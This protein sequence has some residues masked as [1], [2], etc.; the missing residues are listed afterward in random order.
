M[1]MVLGYGY[2]ISHCNLGRRSLVLRHMRIV[3]HTLVL[4]STVSVCP[5]SC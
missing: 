1:R 5:L 4:V 2:I 3:T